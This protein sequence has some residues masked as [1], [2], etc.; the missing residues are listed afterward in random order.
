[1]DEQ[2][3]QILQIL[4]VIAKP[5]SVRTMIDSVALRVEQKLTQDIGASLAWESVPLATYAGRLPNMIRSSWVFVLRA[6]ANTG[7]ER[8]PNSH[9]R[10][11]SY[12]GSGDLQIWTG[13]KW[14]SNPLV[15]NSEAQLESRWVSIPPNTW[16]RALVS[17]KNWIVLSFHTVLED[18]LIEERPDTTDAK[19]TYQRRY[20]D[21][22]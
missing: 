10:M 19:L 3:L 7:A 1:M 22:K 14:R 2:E 15:S 13:K 20:M 12:K 11:M 8:H 21:K 6:Q 9:Q 18:E 4:D 17:E 16:H 5:E